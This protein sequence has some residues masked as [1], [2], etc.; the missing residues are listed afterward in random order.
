MQMKIKKTNLKTLLLKI[1]K[2]DENTQKKQKII[3][4]LDDK[5]KSFIK[6]L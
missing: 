5:L 1:T 3:Q 6:R 2:M 4:K